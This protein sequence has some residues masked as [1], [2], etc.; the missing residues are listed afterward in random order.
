MERD[1]SIVCK[2]ETQ[3]MK[4]LKSYKPC[5]KNGPARTKMYHTYERQKKE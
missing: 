2:D 4:G 3:K 5:P 1:A